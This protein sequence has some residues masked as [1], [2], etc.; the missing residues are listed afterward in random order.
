M[1]LDDMLKRTIESVRGAIENDEILGKPVLVSDGSVILPVIKLSYGFVTGGG[2]YGK[3]KDNRLPYA[4]V[5]GGGATITPIGFLICGREKRFVSLDAACAESK[6]KDLI[7]AILRSF[8]KE[9]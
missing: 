4:S 2:E 1:Q 9:D 5:T 8:K 6:W 7:A 3:Q